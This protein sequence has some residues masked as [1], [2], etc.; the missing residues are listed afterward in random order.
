MDKGHY[1]GMVL[2]DLQKAFDT[3]DHK[4]LLM[5]LE[6]IGL[7][8]D[9]IRWF[10]SYL[11]DR[12]QL[13]DV[14]GTLSSSA[15]IKC[16]VPQGSIL[17]PLLFLIYVNDMSGVV[18]SKLL[19]YADDSAILVSDKHISN[20]EKLLKKEL[21]TVNDWLIDNK[22]SLHLGK[23]ES[24][25]F[26]SK[27]K[28]KS[29]SNLNIS[30]RGTDIQPKERVKYLG[31]T[32]EQSLSGESMVKSIIQKANARLKF[33]YRK[34]KYLNLHTKKLLVMS[35]IQCH[36]DYACSFWY[37]GLTQFLRNRLQTTQNKIIRFVLKMGPRS[38]IGEDAFKAV[39]WLP[40]SKR[41]DQII[42]NHVFKI[43]SGTSPDYMAE[44]FTPASS[45]HSYSTRF[46]Q[47]GCFSLPK[48]KSFGMK[49]FSYRWCILWNYL[50]NSIQV[51]QDFHTYKN[52]VKSHFLDLI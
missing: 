14:S 29:E 15:E 52:S 11:T 4:I 26:G 25:L 9:V 17:G 35:L 37:P 48:A 1:V 18:N 32:L 34:Q 13:V 30:C 12:Q 3:V 41:V 46:R 31:A 7:N 33:L 49:S 22:L 10:R 38:H 36:F 2:L 19:L 8:E 23:T 45:V 47:N 27:I 43:K 50:P 6:A 5:K 28:L 16:G 24:I 40:V 20:I 51:I 39:G 44:Q 21:E 42:L